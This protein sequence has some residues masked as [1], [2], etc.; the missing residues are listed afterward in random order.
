MLQLIAVNLIKC[1][2][3]MALLSSIDHFIRLGHEKIVQILIR[4]GAKVD[5]KD[6]D[7]FTPLHLSAQNGDSLHLNIKKSEGF[8]QKQLAHFYRQKRRGQDS[9]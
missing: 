1:S 5:A 4:S 6:D 7:N 9:N 3:I 8:E 2:E